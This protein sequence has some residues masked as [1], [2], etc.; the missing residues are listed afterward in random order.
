M[1]EPKEKITL[2]AEQETLMI[3]LYCKT[4]GAPKGVFPDEEAWKVVE[5]ID[6]DFK[7][8][9]VKPGTRLTIFIRAKRLDD[10]V[11]GFLAQYPDGIILHLGCGLDTRFFRVDNGRAAWFDLDLPD[12]IELRRKFFADT[13]R[14]RM[15]ASSVTDLRWLEQIPR[16]R[17]VF[18]AAEGLLMYLTEEQVKALLLRLREA[19]PGCEIAFDAFS[20]LTARNIHRADVLKTTG[21][22]VH[23]GIDDPKE[24]ETWAPGIRLKEEWTFF[25]SEDIQKLNLGV[26]LMFG[27]AGLFPAAAKAHRILHYSLS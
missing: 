21:A 8:L 16:G 23:W 20:T 18:I 27:L 26:R 25:Q 9:K 11:R 4:L 22:T 7:R 5:R 6:Y 12:A 14:Y 13:E 3:T 17:P 19:F 15:I 10:Y 1:S 2:T 24:I